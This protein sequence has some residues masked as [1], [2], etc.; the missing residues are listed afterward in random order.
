MTKT[1]LVLRRSARFVLFCCSLVAL[2]L[3]YSCA[4]RRELSLEEQPASLF[5]PEA[6]QESDAAPLDASEAAVLL[7]PSSECVPPYATCAATGS[8]LGVPPVACQVDLRTDPK[9]CGACDNACPE[10]NG[11]LRAVTSCVAGACRA[12]C[13][14][15]TVADCNGI[16]D[17][18]CETD[19]LA[20]PT[21]CGACGKACAPGVK[22]RDGVCGCPAG[23]IDCGGDCIDPKT[24]DKNCGV[25][26]SKCAGADGGAPPPPPPHMYYG[27][28]D[29]KCPRLKCLSPWADCNNDLADGCEVNVERAIPAPP[30]NPFPAEGNYDP[31]NCGACGRACGPS[32]LCI[33]PLLS[34]L[35]CICGAGTTI[36]AQGGL[37]S[38]PDLETDPVNCGSCGFQ[39][40]GR[41]RDAVYSESGKHGEFE[42]VRARC[43]FTCLEPWS[44]CNNDDAD[45]CEANLQFDPNNCG[46]CGM[47]CIPGQLC[48]EGKCAVRECDGGVPR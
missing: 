21:S 32:Q 38:C 14:S 16:I 43:E 25:C 31:T 20:D 11:V 27:C 28:S 1:P 13:I 24:D 36:C 44:D 40:P 48:I 15:P 18:G 30:V 29:A 26:N 37:Y 4:E 10:L 23:L 9:H 47:K 6:G 8:S 22:C 39:C 5:Q 35:T 7:C 33:R 17:D 19:L 45:G 12:A 34:P 46:G 41:T 42:C 3:L 2:L